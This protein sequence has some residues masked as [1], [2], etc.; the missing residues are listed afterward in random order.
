MAKTGKVFTVCSGS[1]SQSIGRGRISREGVLDV[2]QSRERRDEIVPIF[3][4]KKQRKRNLAWKFSLFLA[5]SL[6]ICESR[7]RRDRISDKNSQKRRIFFLCVWVF[8][9]KWVRNDMFVVRAVKCFSEPFCFVIV[10]F[11]KKVFI[12]Y[13]TL[14]FFVICFVISNWNNVKLVIVISIL[15]NHGICS[16][17]ICAFCYK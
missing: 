17:K 3:T 10:I 13:N 2:R 6:V 5:G 14:S 4:P 8:I 11:W 12:C 1:L 9:Q 7:D 15:N 16:K